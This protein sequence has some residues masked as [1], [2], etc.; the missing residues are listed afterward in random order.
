MQDLTTTEKQIDEQMRGSKGADKIPPHIIVQ[1]DAK[2]EP[3]AWTRRNLPDLKDTN[4]TSQKIEPDPET[5]RLKKLV[6]KKNKK[7]NRFTKLLKKSKQIK[8][9]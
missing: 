4:I 6:R 9:P 1:E 3:G 7:E 2:Y 5:E 8:R